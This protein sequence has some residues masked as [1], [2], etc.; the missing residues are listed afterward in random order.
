VKNNYGIPQVPTVQLS[1]CFILCLFGLSV[2]NH[3][4]FNKKKYKI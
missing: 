2:S 1:I 4:Q 3:M